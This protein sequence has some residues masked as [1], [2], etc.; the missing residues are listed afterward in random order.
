VTSAITTTSYCHL[1][2]LCSSHWLRVD[3][4]V[5]QRYRSMQP[6]SLEEEEADSAKKIQRRQAR[7]NNKQKQLQT[8]S[9]QQ[10]QP[11]CL[12]KFYVCDTQPR[13]DLVSTD[14][15]HLALCHHS[16]LKLSS[17]FAHGIFIATNSKAVFLFYFLFSFSCWMLLVGWQQSAS[18]L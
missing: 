8:P 18:E 5:L 13:L 15:L 1:R 14:W 12:S 7:A 6:K 3:A 11:F 9:P 17:H 4:L 10:Q 16:A 2:M